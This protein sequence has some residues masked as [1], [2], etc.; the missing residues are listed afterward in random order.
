MRETGNLIRA[1]RCSFVRCSQAGITCS[2]ES[3]AR[4]CWCAQPLLHRALTRL[5]GMAS[6][7]A[8]ASTAPGDTGGTEAEVGGGSW[9][10]VHALNMV[11]L[12]FEER[13]LATDTLPF[14]AEGAAF[15][16]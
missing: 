10:R 1:S 2:H 11:R 7:A 3:Q 4:W 9:P 12:V 15:G 5:L 13:P 6:G 14:L 8:A 16:A